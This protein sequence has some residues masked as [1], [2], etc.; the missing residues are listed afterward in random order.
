VTPLAPYDG[1][2]LVTAQARA[3]TAR[4][5]LGLDV[6]IAALGQ[7][8]ADWEIVNS[9]LEYAPESVPDIVAA[10]LQ[11][12]V[13]CAVGVSGVA[14]AEPLPNPLRDEIRRAA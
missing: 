4:I 10:A 11:R 8:Q 5:L 1:T 2:D 6:P 13:T 14:T 9:A 7:I 12:L 3:G